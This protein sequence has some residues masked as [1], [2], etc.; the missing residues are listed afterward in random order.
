MYIIDVKVKVLIVLLVTWSYYFVGCIVVYQRSLPTFINRKCKRYGTTRVRER[1]KSNIKCIRLNLIFIW[2]SYDRDFVFCQLIL[3]VLPKLILDLRHERW[4][5]PCYS[6]H[7]ERRIRWI[8][9][10]I[11]LLGGP[12]VRVT[13]LLWRKR[14]LYDEPRIILIL[15]SFSFYLIH[16]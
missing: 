16:P 9:E 7:V 12:S 1:I 10:V 5:L 4:C 2:L 14:S 13:I 3:S 11:K 8:L 6:T 15:S